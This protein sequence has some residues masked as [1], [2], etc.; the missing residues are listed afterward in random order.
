MSDHKT[1][2][3]CSFH[4]Q[5]CIITEYLLLFTL[6]EMKVKALCQ[7]SAFLNSDLVHRKDAFLINFPILREIQTLHLIKLNLKIV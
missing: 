1:H 6:R 4:H 3:T 7:I 5:R 2:I